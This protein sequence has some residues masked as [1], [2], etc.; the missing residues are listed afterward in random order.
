[1]AEVIRFMGANQLGFSH[2]VCS[3]CGSDR[4]HIET[5]DSDGTERFKWLHCVSCGNQIPVNMTPC[6]GSR[7]KEGK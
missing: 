3:D 7:N 6:F 2:V 4:F 1:M 5:D